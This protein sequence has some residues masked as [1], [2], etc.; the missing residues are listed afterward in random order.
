MAAS[1]NTEIVLLPGDILAAV[2]GLTG[3]LS[4]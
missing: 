3:T 1:N 4:R 2:R